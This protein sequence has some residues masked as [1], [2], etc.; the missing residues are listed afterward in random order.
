MSFVFKTRVLPQDSPLCICKDYKIQASSWWTGL[1][2]LNC[3]EGE[4][5]GGKSW[6]QGS[7]ARSSS[8]IEATSL[9]QAGSI[10]GKWPELRQ[11]LQSHTSRHLLPSKR[12]Y[13]PAICL[14]HKSIEELKHAQSLDTMADV[15]SKADTENQAIELKRKL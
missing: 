1:C 8:R 4:P 3:G 12:P 9:Q 7:M 11:A 15:T 13:L 14:K 5:H 6:C 10:N 2:F